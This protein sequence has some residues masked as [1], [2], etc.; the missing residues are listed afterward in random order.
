MNR[1]TAIILLALFAASCLLGLGS[2]KDNTEDNPQ[3]EPDKTYTVTWKNYNG[4][5]LET[6]ANVKEGSLPTYNGATPT[7][8]ADEQYTYVFDGW[9]PQISEVRADVTYTAKFTQRLNGNLIDGVDP[10]I[11]Q[12]GKTIKYGFY[13]QTRV[14]DEAL[15]A[16]LNA[17][18]PSQTNGW[19]LLN[20]EYY[21]KHTANVYN[22]ESYTFDDG[23]AIVNG[24]EYWFKCEA[25]EWQVISD[26]NGTY[27]LLSAKLL[28]AHNYYSNYSN[29]TIGGNTVYANNYEQSD[30]RSWL[31]GYFYNTA[32]ALNNEYIQQ[33]TVNN[34]ASTTDATNNP[35]AC[36][37]TQDKVCLPSYQDYLNDSYGFGTNA[38]AASST[39][40]CKTTDYARANGAW[41]NATSKLQY[42]GSY[43]TRS[44]SSEYNYCAWNVN[45]AGYL[46]AYAVD[47]NS[48]CVRPCITVIL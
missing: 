35:Y 30:V 16:E 13:P 31:N 6:D 12:D 41:C 47:G 22:N 42:N 17:L 37:N 26:V 9:E 19:Y 1:K 34:G 10:V 14:N 2:C 39:R 32:F 48:H 38:D 25:I 21:A 36:A 18:T 33:T 7:K 40:E 23:T 45:S 43:W 24:N 5:V 29:R 20:G 27:C 3:N 46:S 11:S 28:D 15:I 44:P 4:E 8:N